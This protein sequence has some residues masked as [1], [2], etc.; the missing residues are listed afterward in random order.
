[1]LEKFVQAIIITFLLNLTLGLSG[2]NSTNVRTR[3]PWQPFPES[4]AR[5]VRSRR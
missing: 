5:F 4:I 1:M 2:R 3:Q